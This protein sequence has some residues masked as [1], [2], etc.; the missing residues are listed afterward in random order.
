MQILEISLSNLSTL[1][2]HN[3]LCRSWPQSGYVGIA[4]PVY[5]QCIFARNA[6]RALLLNGKFR[7]T[8]H[9]H[10]NRRRHNTTT[11]RQQHFLDFEVIL[12]SKYIAENIARERERNNAH[13]I[14]TQYKSIYP[15]ST[16]TNAVR[17]LKSA[18]QPWLNRTNTPKTKPK[19]NCRSL[20]L[21]HICV[22]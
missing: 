19:K 15:A 14:H 11:N 9:Y 8:P 13:N 10:S 4:T 2:F 12:I 7:G 1:T 16:Y 6:E 18:H 22:V 3:K 21:V 20:R 17:L 5:T